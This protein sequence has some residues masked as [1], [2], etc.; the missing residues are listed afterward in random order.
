MKNTLKKFNFFVAEY[1]K[2][3]QY[4]IKEADTF[5]VI[6][7]FFFIFFSVVSYFSIPVLFNYK[8]I[9]SKIITKINSDFKI[10]LKNKG[11]INY[12]FIP[13]PHL[14]IENSD[15][16]IH[17]D[18][19]K[20]IA[21]LKNIKVFVS[22]IELYKD[23]NIKIDK[24]Q[25]KKANFYFD[26]N[27]IHEFNKHLYF[28]IYKPIEILKS[29]FFYIDKLNEVVTI[30]PIK[31]LNYFIDYKSKEKK[32]EL[33]GNIFDTDYDYKYKKN[34]DYPSES[35]IS[36]F[37]KNP[38]I[39]IQNKF[40]KDILNKKNNGKIKINFLNNEMDINYNYV[41][42][43]ITFNSKESK[44]NYF[45]NKG[46]IELDP[47]N[48]EIEVLINNENLN[49][50]FNNIISDIINFPTHQN[51]NG[52][53]SITLKDIN[54]D[55]FQSGFF[56]FAFREQ[57]IQLEKSFFKI[58]KIG[59]INILN[60]KIIE[61]LDKIFLKL[62]VELLVNNKDEFFRRFSIPKKHKIDLR[63]IY[64][65]LEKD[66]D[67]NTFYISKI[68]LNEKIPNNKNELDVN[69]KKY[70]FT[71]VQQLRNIVRNKF[72]LSN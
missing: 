29:N 16:R 9:E 56:N 22:L 28:K 62:E 44:N 33:K 57:K 48:F 38:N 12:G 19:K 21:N 7:F 20:E 65:N 5:K 45:V 1:Q 51:L 58:K 67:E 26:I 25:I 4:L 61:D 24:I 14:L 18:S 54:N 41:N 40:N 23:T 53:L 46:L 3:A 42:N 27:N 43:L 11:K 2:K 66:L 39:K 35:K 68:G 63:K 17:K 10:Y 30:S 37:F 64:F 69:F 71:N 36:L 8:N 6:L 50:I 34:F 55:F 13:S 70:K 60:Y 31:Q 32:L 47:F 72:S 59:N 52:N 15:L 49:F